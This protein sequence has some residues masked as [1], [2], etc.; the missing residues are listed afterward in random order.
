MEWPFLLSP[1]NGGITPLHVDAANK[2]AK[3]P[4][5][6][7]V[8]AAPSPRN[9]HWVA[10][11]WRRRQYAISTVLTLHPAPWKKTSK[12]GSAW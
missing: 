3:I 6:V 8:T 1:Q 5:P 12:T 11:T 7:A 2:G 9:W 10:K 4:R